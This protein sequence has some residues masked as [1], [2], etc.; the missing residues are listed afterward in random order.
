MR[1]R[2]VVEHDGNKWKCGNMSRLEGGKVERC[3]LEQNDGD[4]NGV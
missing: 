4:E 1:G 3:T 2:G